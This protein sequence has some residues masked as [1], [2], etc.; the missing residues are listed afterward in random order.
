MEENYARNV[1]DVYISREGYPM[2]TLKCLAMYPIVL[3]AAT[4]SLLFAVCCHEA[5]F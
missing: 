2:L 5:Y 1:P 4:I 3:F